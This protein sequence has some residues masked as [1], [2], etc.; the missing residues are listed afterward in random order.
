M[1]DERPAW[2]GPPSEELLPLRVGMTLVQ[3]EKLL[4]EATLRYTGGNVKAAAHMLGIDRSTVYKKMKPYGI[5]NEANRE[6]P[7]VEAPS[8]S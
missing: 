1:N 4:I 3:A 6:K 8:D 5:V 7:R 2:S